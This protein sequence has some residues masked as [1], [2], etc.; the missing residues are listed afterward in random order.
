MN[1]GRTIFSQLLDLAPRYEFQECVKKY[2][3]GVVAR[4]FS[5]WDQFLSMSFAQLTYRES[6]RDIESCLQSLGKKKY[7]LGLRCEVKRTTLAYANENRD[8]RIWEEYA[9]ILIQKVRPLYAKDNLEFN[10]ENVAY[11]LDSTT[12]TLC[13]S[14]FP[15]AKYRTKAKAIKLHTQLDL[16]GNIPSFIHISKAKMADVRF[17]DKIILEPGALYVMDRGYLDFKRLYKFTLHGCFFVTR[18]KSNIY[19]RRVEIF[20]RDRHASIRMDAA[21]VLLANTSRKLYPQR[22]RLVEYYDVKT[23]K[24]LI[25]ITNNFIL[26]AQEVADIYRARWQVELFFKWIKQ[27]L[28]IKAFYGNS[29]NAVKTQIW[30]AVS[31]YLLVALLKKQLKLEQSP[32]TILQILS[33][34][35]TEKIPINSAFQQQNREIPESENYKQLSLFN[36]P[37][38]Q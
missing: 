13:M 27:N 7:G 34:C 25:F 23:K 22:L 37:I 5:L 20:T 24:L 32:R 28:R 33:I 4:R 30:I 8:W 2:G 19:Y 14:L 26:T 35:S 18:L 11:V 36:F 21:I 12:I 10:F 15:W 17:L 6:L 3:E 31:V 29:E 16:R 38:G 1:Q 9:Q